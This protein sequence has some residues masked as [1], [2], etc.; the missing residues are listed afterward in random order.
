MDLVVRINFQSQFLI[1]HG[2]EV[3]ELLRKMEI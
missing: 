1:Q 2:Q 3:P